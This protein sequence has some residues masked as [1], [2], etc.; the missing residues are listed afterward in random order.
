MVSITTFSTAS[1]IRRLA[2]RSS[3]QPQV[4]RRQ[5][6]PHHVRFIPAQFGYTSGGVVD[7]VSRS[8][9]NQLHG[10]VYEFFRNDILDAEQAFPRPA[11]QK[12]KTRYNNYGGTLGGPIKR[13]KLFIFG[14]YEQY[15]FATNNPSYFTLPTAQEMTG[16]FS[17]LGT[18]RQRRLHS[19][20]YLRRYEY[21]GWSTATVRLQRHCQ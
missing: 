11:L 21:R 6:I 10:S 2:R 1:R 14:N 20:Q 19:G 13:D 4:R 15:N 7:V 8:G 18:D 5:R 16:N 3:H 9:S 17:D 12:Q